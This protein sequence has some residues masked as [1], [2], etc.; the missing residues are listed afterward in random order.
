MSYDVPMASNPAQQALQGM[1]WRQQLRTGFKD[2]GHRS[3]SSA[4]NFGMVGA[5][6]AGTE[7][8]IEGVCVVCSF[9]LQCLSTHFEPYR[10][11]G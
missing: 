5:I 10:V 8:G 4:K 9:S 7:C 3:F 11:V 6:Y 2:M 1:N